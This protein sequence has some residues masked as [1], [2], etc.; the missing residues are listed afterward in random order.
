MFGRYLGS[1]AEN[2][3]VRVLMIICNRLFT[4][5]KTYLYACKLVHSFPHVHVKANDA[6]KSTHLYYHPSH[7]RRNHIMYT[8]RDS[9]R[10]DRHPCSSATINN[11]IYRKRTA[12]KHVDEL[13]KEDRA[14]AI[15][16]CHGYGYIIFVRFTY[17][18]PKPQPMNMSLIIS[19]ITPVSIIII[20]SPIYIR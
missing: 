8:S 4:C 9:Y 20:T 10:V 7:I 17:T 19:V 12:V 11:K 14:A 16:R 15:L 3:S 6:R 13:T 18:G 5:N 2:R 1:R